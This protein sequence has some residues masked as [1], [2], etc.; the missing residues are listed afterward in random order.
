[1]N[2]N[3]PATAPLQTDC[4]LSR[5]PWVI[6]HWLALYLGLAILAFVLLQDFH[7]IAVSAWF[8]FCLGLVVLVDPSLTYEIR[9]QQIWKNTVRKKIFYCEY[10]IFRLEFIKDN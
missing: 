9:N 4:Q 1:M 6:Y 8:L 5:K 3:S 2:E 10:S 7:Q